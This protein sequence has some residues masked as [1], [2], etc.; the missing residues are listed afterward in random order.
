MHVFPSLYDDTLQTKA[1]YSHVMGTYVN[2]GFRLAAMT[3]CQFLGAVLL[4]VTGKTARSAEYAANIAD[5]IAQF[6]IIT[7]RAT[8]QTTSEY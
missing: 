5:I 6:V 4:S 2:S 8:E 3:I 7:A 1:P